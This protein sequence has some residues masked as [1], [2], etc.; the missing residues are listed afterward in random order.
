MEVELGKHLHSRKNTGF[1]REAIG[2]S[3]RESKSTCVCV[4]ACVRECIIFC[5]LCFS[6]STDNFC[7]DFTAP[8]SGARSC[9]NHQRCSEKAE[10][11]LSASKAVSRS[12]R[13]LC[14]LVLFM[15]KQALCSFTTDFIYIH[16]LK[17]MR[18]KQQSDDT[19][20]QLRPTQ[21]DTLL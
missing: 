11:E 10:L 2:H 1:K 4:S 14:R 21:S 18:E 16:L 6:S 19:W 15:R 13:G 12:H 3:Y 20:E 9:L 7:S 8:A 17:K 5:D